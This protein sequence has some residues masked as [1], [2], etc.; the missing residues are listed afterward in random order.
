LPF[1]ADQGWSEE[2]V[3]EQVLTP[4]EESTLK[5]TTPDPKPIMCYQI[6]GSVTKDGKPIIGGLDIS[7][8]A[9]KDPKFSY[10]VYGHTHHH[11]VIPLR[12]GKEHNGIDQVVYINSGSWRAVFDLARVHRRDE[13]FFGIT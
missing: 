1:H 5:G 11:E 9:F 10:I 8:E 6:P 13:E 4:I 2:E 3:R 7:E 12:D